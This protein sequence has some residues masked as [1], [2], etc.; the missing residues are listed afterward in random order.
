MNQTVTEQKDRSRLT[1]SEPIQGGPIQ[2]CYAQREQSGR[3][4]L[5]EHLVKAQQLHEDYKVIFEM[6]PS[7]MSERQ[8][9]ALRNILARIH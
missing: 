1:E 9:R 4:I 5:T 3:D 2:N 7:K 8:E 6:L